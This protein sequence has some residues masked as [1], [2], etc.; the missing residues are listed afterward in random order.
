MILGVLD[1]RVEPGLK[2]PS[3]SKINH[4]NHEQAPANY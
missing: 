2:I 1:T 4:N 3:S